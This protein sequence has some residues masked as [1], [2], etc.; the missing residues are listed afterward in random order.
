M[1]FTESFNARMPAAS[2]A[3]VSDI[4]S[5]ALNLPCRNPEE[6]KRRRNEGRAD[7]AIGV[8]AGRP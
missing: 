7:S 2:M 3:V 1:T 5:N 4:S 8:S 6:R